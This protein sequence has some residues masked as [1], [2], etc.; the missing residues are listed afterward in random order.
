MA[1]F[2]NTIYLLIYNKDNKKLIYWS[3]EYKGFFCLLDYHIQA[4]HPIS[5]KN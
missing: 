1:Y 4:I 5:N 2:M 3:L